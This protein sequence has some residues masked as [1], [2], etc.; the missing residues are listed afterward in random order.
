VESCGPGYDPDAIVRLL[1]DKEKEFWGRF[2]VME[3][4]PK[5]TELIEL[6]DICKRIDFLY[7][8]KQA[9]ACTQALRQNSSGDD[10]DLEMLKALNDTLVHQRT[11]GSNNG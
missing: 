4:P 11:T 6:A 3:A 8:E 7:K 1:D 9:S 10:Y 2:R 5:E